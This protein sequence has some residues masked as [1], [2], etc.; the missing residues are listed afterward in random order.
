[1][2]TLIIVAHPNLND[3]VINK[4]WLEV[5]K[6]DPEQYTVHDLYEAYPDGHIDVEKEQALIEAHEHIVFQFPLYWFNATPL[7]KKWLDDVLTHGWAYGSESGY[8]LKNRHIALAVSAGIKEADYAA[9]GRYRYTL[10]E[11][12]RPFEITINYVHARYRS[13][14]AFYGAE[15]AVKAEEVEQSAQDYLAFLAALQGPSTGF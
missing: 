14:F 13:F 3:S 7:L 4:K 1:M 15:G 8:K 5:L 11:V 12:L 2:K 10:E 6:Q 9:E